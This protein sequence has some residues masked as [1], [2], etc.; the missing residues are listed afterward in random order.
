MEQLLMGWREMNT[1][2]ASRLTDAQLLKMLE[3]MP[4]KNGWGLVAELMKRY[5]RNLP[6]P[7]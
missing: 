5:N 4:I 3:Q 2:F 6:P 1:D 7:K